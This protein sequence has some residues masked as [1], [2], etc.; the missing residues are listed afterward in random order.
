[1]TVPSEERYEK[2]IVRLRESTKAFD[3]AQRDWDKVRGNSI[4]EDKARRAAHSAGVAAIQACIQFLLGDKDVHR[5]RLTRPLGALE[6]AAYDALQGA[7]PRLLQHSPTRTGK[8]ALTSR[9]QVQG[10]LAG[11]L[12]L[13]M[14]AKMGT[15]VAA[16]WVA[17]EAQKQGVTSEDC[18]PIAPRQI[19]SSR[20]EIIQG[21]APQGAKDAFYLLTN[22]YEKRLE[23]LDLADRREGAE[24]LARA[25][26]KSLAAISPVSAP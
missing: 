22:A 11:A 10:V 6:S 12:D 25:A 5:E 18:T 20:K 1:M 17:K 14:A 26:I 7:N 15:H 24:A 16:V 21:R 2:L 23:Q 19:I 9:E 13:L 3:A 8:A 4:K